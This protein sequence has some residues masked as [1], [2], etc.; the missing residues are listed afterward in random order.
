MVVRYCVGQEAEQHMDDRQWPKETSLKVF[1]AFLG[2]V[3][4]ADQPGEVA[5]VGLGRD[6]MG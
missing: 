5:S 2:E 3:L 1:N 4:C 6:G